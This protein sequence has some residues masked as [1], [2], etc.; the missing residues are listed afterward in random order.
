MVKIGKYHY[1]LSTNK[2][3]KLM[4]I[5]DGKVIHFG[6]TG[7]EHVFDKTRLTDIKLNHMDKKRQ[8]NYLKRSK[9]ITNKNGELTY[10]NPNSSNY[11]AIRILW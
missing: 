1:E 7:Y 9:G 2:N 5:V 3:K 4:T 10:K 11:H 8:T 6:Q